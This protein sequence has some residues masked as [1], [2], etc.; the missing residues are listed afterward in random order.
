MSLQPRPQK[1][2]LHPIAILL[3]FRNIHLIVSLLFKEVSP[4]HPTNNTY[5]YLAPSARLAFGYATI[6][7][8]DVIHISN[9]TTKVSVRRGLEC[10]ANKPFPFEI[11]DLLLKPS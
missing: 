3:A 6:A 10:M 1:P 2:P 9:L 7:R 8:P 11:P 5:I 4:S